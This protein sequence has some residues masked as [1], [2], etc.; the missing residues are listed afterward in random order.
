MVALEG[1]RWDGDRTGPRRFPRPDPE[2]K[3]SL[4]CCVSGP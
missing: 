4:A 2:G 3:Q 1:E